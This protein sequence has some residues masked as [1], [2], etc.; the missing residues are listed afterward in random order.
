[1]Q[2]RVDGGTV[3]MDQRLASALLV[4]RFPGRK[5]ATLIWLIFFL[6]IGWGS[7]FQ[8]EPASA[9]DANQPIK[10][11]TVRGNKRIEV[12]A[13]RNRVTLKE[14]D[15]FTPDAVREQIRAI[16]QMGYFEDVRVEA[17][18]APGGVTV[19]FVVT[20]KPFIT[21]ILF[22]GNDKVKDEKLREK[23]TVRNQSFL[24]QQ[25]VKD[26]VERLRLLYEEEGHFSARVVPVLKTLDADRKSLTF[27]ITEGPKAR[28]KTVDFDGAKAIPTRQLKKPLI[29]REH[30]L[31]FSWFDDS[32]I[33]KKEELANDVERIRQLYLDEGYLNVQVGTPTVDLSVDKKWFTIRFP[34]VEGPQ[35]KLGKIDYAGQTVLTEAEL[36]TGSKLKEGDV[37]RMA[38]LRDDITR[39]TDLYGSKG[40]SFTDVD[41]KLRSRRAPWFISA[42]SILR[43]MTKRGTRSSVANCA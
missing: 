41:P 3:L 10:S 1:V 39:V 35:F 31:L 26:S 8:P 2:V 30:S 18:P 21:E 34:I 5:V 43:A 6:G 7:S 15:L 28:I 38:Q 32:G 29:T 25:Q 4:G 13:I 37:V 16:Y 33:Y 9:Q 20:E 42:I 11:I 12:P 27:F 23:M 40:Y 19:A 17:E 36:R 14:G 22:D 24:D